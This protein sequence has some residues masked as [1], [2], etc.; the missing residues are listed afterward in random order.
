MR[1]HKRTSAGID[2]RLS[3]HQQS[4]NRR[5]PPLVS[6]FR[7]FDVSAFTLVELMVVIAII[8][9]LISILLPSL[10]AVR[11]QVKV[12]ATKTTVS[13]L[14]TGVNQFQ[15]DTRCGGSL[16]PS[17]APPTTVSGFNGGRIVNPLTGNDA[18]VEGASLLFWALAGADQLGT[19]GFTDLDGNGTWADNTGPGAGGL[20]AIY[21]SNHAQPTLRNKPVVV[22]SG[23]FIEI[24]K[25]KLPQ[26]AVPGDLSRGFAVPVAKVNGVIASP[27]FLDAFDQPILYYK[28]NANRSLMAGA[29]IGTANLG[30]YNLMDNFGITGLQGTV[31][32]MDLGRG[33]VDASGLFH[34]A[35]I[36]GE[37]ADGNLSSVDILTAM[38]DPTNRCFSR[39]IWNPNVV[40]VPRPHNEKSFILL[41][42]G[43]DGVFGTGDDI[44]N[45]EVNK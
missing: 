2:G 15:A 29:A 10:G 23:P 1:A 31:V 9:V 32:G 45:F 3:G 14:E 22:R 34:F 38:N 44:A 26:P 27:C 30:T 42:A 24:S 18:R 39:T 28:A 33:P 37:G 8:A 21:P 41:S 12:A 7:R 11:T 40:A 17:A 16:P 4:S 20:Y 35:G 13:V 25:M 43:P 6:A 5:I 19:P 36:P